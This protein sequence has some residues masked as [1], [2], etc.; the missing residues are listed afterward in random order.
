MGQWADLPRRLLTVSIGAPLIVC[1]LANKQSAY[2]FFQGA[3]LLCT[4]EWLKLIPS[5][6]KIKSDTPSK[7]KN[8]GEGNGEASKHKVDANLNT[9]SIAARAFPIL[10]ILISCSSE[11]M[12]T[13]LLSITAAVV[14]LSMYMQGEEQKDDIERTIRHLNHGF[15]FLTLP[16]YHWI[17]LSQQSFASTFFVLFTAW[18]CDTGALLAGRIGKMIFSSNDIVGDILIQSVYGKAMMQ[19]V[20][21]ISPSKSITGFSG[22]ISLGAATSY[23]MP[24]FLVWFC[25]I[26]KDC[27]VG[28]VIGFR[29]TEDLLN[30]FDFESLAWISSSVGIRRI[31]VG[32]FLSLFGIIGDLV[33]SAV[34]R[35]AGKKDSGKLLPGHGGII[36]RFDSTFLAIAIYML[37]V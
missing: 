15:L 22:G 14:Y 5:A 19:F 2:V 24:R 34:K 37:I 7:N 10:S 9:S 17:R 8:F 11:K 1:L 30:M 36:D 18:N 32:S 31:L 21:R 26:I 35:N 3:H 27:G 29:G 16:F 12:I 20:K 23:Y 25:T 6:G 4:F 13:L 33:E 28:E